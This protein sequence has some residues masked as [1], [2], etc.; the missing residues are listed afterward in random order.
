MKLGVDVGGTFTD[1]FLTRDGHDPQIFKTLSTPEDPSI[2]VVTGLKEIA[3]SLDPAMTLEEF[4]AGLETIVHGTTVTT[5]AVLTRRG[6][7]SG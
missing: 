4:A 1:F 2:A 6:A 7:K 5:N 3:A